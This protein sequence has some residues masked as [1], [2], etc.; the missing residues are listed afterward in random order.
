MHILMR[1]PV[2][3]RI[4]PC[5]FSAVSVVAS[6]FC[7]LYGVVAEIEGCDLFQ[8]ALIKYAENWGFSD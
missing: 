3:E 1:S 7:I 5:Q 6:L 4:C 8:A 2:I